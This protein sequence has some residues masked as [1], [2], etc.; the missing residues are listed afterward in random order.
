[1]SRD[2]A[3]RVERRDRVLE[4]HLHRGCA[5]CA[6]PRRRASSSSWPSKMTLPARRRGS[7]MIARPV[8]DLPQPDSPTSP[9][10]SPGSTSRLMSET[11]LTLSPVRPDRELDD[12]VLDAQQG[13]AL[14]AA[15]GRCRCR[16]S[17][18]AA[19]CRGGGR[20]RADAWPDAVLGAPMSTLRPGSA[21][22]SPSGVPTGY[23]QRERVAGSSASTAAAPPRGTGPARTGTAARTGS[24]SAG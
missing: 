10:V 2:L 9:S 23:Q 4:D 11:A 15:G 7:C 12:E 3:A 22:A 17:G 14:R 1:M 21:S 5:P 16:P 13:L 24:P 8:V 6:A 20:R 18:S 19:R